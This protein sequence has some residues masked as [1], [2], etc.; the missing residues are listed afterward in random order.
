M[1]IWEKMIGVQ[2]RIKIQFADIDEGNTLI[3]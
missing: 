1:E 3:S 2:N